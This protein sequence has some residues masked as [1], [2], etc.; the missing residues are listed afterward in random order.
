[1]KR[2]QFVKSLAGTAALASSLSLSSCVTEEESL[3][4]L[5]LGGTNFLGPSIVEAAIAR[6]HQI[7][8]F[9]RGISNPTLY[10]QL[11]LFKGDRESGIEGYSSL[12]DQEWDLVIDVW[13]E[14]S[15]LV[16][17]ATKVFQEKARHYVFISSIAVYNNF[18]EVGL[19][20]SSNLVSLELDKVDWE[21]PEEKHAAEN[22][23]RERF[24]SN[25][26]ILR[27][28]PIT[29]WRNPAYDL[30]YWCL[31]LSSHEPFIAPGSGQDPLQFIDVKDVGRFAIQAAE[32]KLLGTYNC[33]GPGE[34]K[35]LWK[36]FIQTAQSHF[37]SNAKVYWASEEFFKKHK[38]YSF[39]DMPLW[40]PLSEDP[41]FMQISNEKLISSGFTYRPMTETLDDCLKWYS[42]NVQR[43]IDFGA[44]EVGL[45]LNRQHELDLI[46]LLEAGLE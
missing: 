15:R 29:G 9:N 36:D 25:H 33:V 44:A 16:D 38:I 18:Q 39:S 13:P 41:G 37:N 28:G 11:Q 17:D 4:I 26:S 34:E 46:K 32:Q 20:E 6:N 12:A 19:H 2:R 22:F 35:L 7:S 40:A 21:Y 3:K 27:P 31:K 42:Q 5:V 10:P 14:K 30:L 23:V 24:P 8:L 45:G 1:M 43:T